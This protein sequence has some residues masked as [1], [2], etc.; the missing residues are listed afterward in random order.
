MKL[1]RWGMVIDLR[2]C[3]GCGACVVACAEAN[4][5]NSNLWRRV[6]DCGI[7]RPPMRQRLYLPLNCMHCDDPPCE[8]VCPTTATYRRPDGIVGIDLDKCIG[9]GYCI[10]ACPYHAR[11]IIFLNEYNIENRVMGAGNEPSVAMPDYL[12]VCTKCNFCNARLDSGIEKGLKP[13]EDSEASPACVVH[14]TAGALHFGDLNDSE[15]QVTHLVSENKTFCLRED[16]G[17]QPRVYYIVNPNLI[18]E[19]DF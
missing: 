15:S 8:K 10:V 9:C 12:G 2:K 5:I 4:K 3:I 1:P 19:N 6:F 7:S 14:C 18:E 13:G 16:L 17:T 11:A